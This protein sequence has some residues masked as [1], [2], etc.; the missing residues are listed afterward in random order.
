MARWSFN[1]A[2]VSGF[3]SALRGGKTKGWDQER[4]CRRWGSLGVEAA[5][6]MMAA[7]RMGGA[8]VTDRRRETTW[9]GWCWAESLL[10]LGLTSGNSKEN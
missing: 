7:G 6:S 3:D 10:W 1:E 8:A 9:V 4:K 2:A 5:L